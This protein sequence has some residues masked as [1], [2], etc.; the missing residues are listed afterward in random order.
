MKWMIIYSIIILCGLS[1]LNAQSKTGEVFQPP[2]SLEFSEEELELLKKH[3]FYSIYQT[4]PSYEKEIQFTIRR[5]L[6]GRL[7]YFRFLNLSDWP[8]PQYQSIDEIEASLPD[9]FKLWPTHPGSYQIA[10]TN[11]MESLFRF[12]YQKWEVV[13]GK[14]TSILLND[15]PNQ[16]SPQ[17]E[18]IAF[19]ILT[20]SLDIGLSITT[21]NFQDYV[22]IKINECFSQLYTRK[23]L[24]I[25]GIQLWANYIA[26]I[27]HQLN[28]LKT[29]NAA[30]SS[31]PN[32]ISLSL[33]KI[34]DESYLGN[35][36]KEE[37][38]IL[39][40]KYQDL[41]SFKRQQ[42]FHFIKPESLL[43]PLL[44]DEPYPAKCAFA[45]NFA[46]QTGMTKEE[47]EKHILPAL[48]GMHRLEERRKFIEAMELEIEQS[49]KRNQSRETSCPYQEYPHQDGTLGNG[50]PGKIIPYESSTEL[51]RYLKRYHL[52]AYW[53]VRDDYPHTDDVTPPGTFP[54]RLPFLLFTPNKKAKKLPIV[55]YFGGLGEMGTNLVS[56]F[57]QP[58]IFEQICSPA[59]QEKHPCYLITPMIPH[60]YK[61][62]F[63]VAWRHFPDHMARLV[64]DCLYAVIR[65]ET[66]PGIDLNRMYLTGLSC[67]GTSAFSLSL[68]YPNRFAASIPI[69][70]T[71]KPTV[72]PESHAGNYWV[73]YNSG[74]EYANAM[75]ENLA[76]LKPIIEKSGGTLRISTY[77]DT[78]HDAWQKAWREEAI[79]EWLFRHSTKPQ[80]IVSNNKGT[81]KKPA[82]HLTASVEGKQGYSLAQCQDSLDGSWFESER[83]VQEGDWIQIER[84]EKDTKRVTF[85]FGLPNGTMRP[86]R[87]HLE[88][89][90]NGIH[91]TRG[92]HYSEKTGT[93]T[94]TLPSDIR[95][96]RFL[97]KPEHPEI[98]VVRK[99]LLE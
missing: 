85:Y 87:G 50:F 62:F 96:I 94:M 57:R 3:R 30:D 4:I 46:I 7:P 38:L 76:T 73:L 67:G 55:M 17:Y 1:P 49:I 66:H 20:N 2:K 42:I 40:K 5:F 58:T 82:Y 19:T 84:D 26:N 93:A 47:R 24:T 53:F 69:A 88:V 37:H 71:V 14:K 68:A 56:Q 64:C 41:L 97:P 98:L 32:E 35:E 10:Y 43:I 65:K 61:T 70:G 78:G 18:T 99:I 27:N 54:K 77:G 44:H 90:R 13:H 28:A 79:W 29:K 12:Y 52:Q 45:T 6:K 9:V 8:I 92:T 74:D 21:T 15:Y 36:S 25:N 23:L 83:P 33:Y 75:K 48:Q 31:L 72:I 91:W 86:T 81:T 39:I 34:L 51:H 60:T 63:G 11:A 95:F 16:F 59:F 80:Q 89:S 22:D